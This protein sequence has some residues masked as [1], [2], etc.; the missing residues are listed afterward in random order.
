M[1]I[2]AIIGF[3]VGI[4]GLGFGIASTGKTFGWW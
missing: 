3:I 1:V 4:V 2:L